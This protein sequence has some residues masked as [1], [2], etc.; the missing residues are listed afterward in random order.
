MI[1]KV[2][3]KVLVTLITVLGSIVTA[4]LTTYGVIRA[5]TRGIS[6]NQQKLSD[7]NAKTDALAVLPVGTVIASLLTPTKFAKQVGDPDNFDVTKSSWTLADG[8]AVHGTDWAKLRADAP[9]PNLCGTFLRGKNNGTRGDV[10]E[11]DLGVYQPDT[12][13]PHRHKLWINNKSTQNVT[14]FVYNGGSTA[15]F[16][17]TDMMPLSD[18]ASETQPKNVTVNYFVRIN[19]LKQLQSDILRRR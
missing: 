17:Y 7:L 12:V 19:Q 1:G 13:G 14:G 11:T 15:T 18:E 4:G 2:S 9:V 16:G 3:D 10:K 6:E 5:N 8:K